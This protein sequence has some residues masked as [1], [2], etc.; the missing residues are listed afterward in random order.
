MRKKFNPKQY[1][2]K[3]YQKLQSLTQGSKSVEDYHKKIEVAIIR[4]NVDIDRQVTM[5]RFL[6]ILNLGIANVVELQLWNLYFD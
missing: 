5:S 3:L 2:R 4:A 6:H 1:Y